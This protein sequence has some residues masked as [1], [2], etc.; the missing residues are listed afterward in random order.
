MS[1]TGVLVPSHIHNSKLRDRRTDLA[2]QV[3][4]PTSTFILDASRLSVLPRP[5]L[6]IDV[7]CAV[8]LCCSR[9]WYLAARVTRSKAANGATKLI[10]ICMT[11]AHSLEAAMQCARYIYAAKDATANR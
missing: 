11:Y 6:N 7:V 3:L 10:R 9:R 1:F 5:R 8:D 2:L 4:R